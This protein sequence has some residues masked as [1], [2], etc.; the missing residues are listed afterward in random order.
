MARLK[1][2]EKKLLSERTP[3]IEAEKVFELKDDLLGMITEMK[4]MKKSSGVGEIFHYFLAQ[5]AFN[6]YLKNKRSGDKTAIS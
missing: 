4:F 6:H 5:L 3:S 2:R 1:F